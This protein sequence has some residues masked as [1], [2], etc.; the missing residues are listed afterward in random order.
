[1]PGFLIAFE[2]MDQSGKATQARQ[3][4]AR[5]EAAG[6]QVESLSFP[7]YKTSIGMEIGHALQG[8]RNY[9]PDTM[10]LL[11]MANRYEFRPRIEEWLAEGRFVICDRYTASSVAYGESQ[12]LDPSWVDSVQTGLPRAA[13]T[14]LLD[15]AAEH[16]ARRKEHDRDKYE[17][18]L[19][20]L[21][22]VR[23]SYLR[24]ARQHGWVVLDATRPVG[25]VAADVAREVI[26]RLALP[27]T[28]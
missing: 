6:Y 18:D 22:R 2:G 17:R 4:H 12:G 27:S 19:A 10:Q 20:M 26:S 9:G 25:E 24:Q 14:L 8:E 21:G 23:E 16:A 28:H 11:Y 15:L 13:V 5:L 1:M 7:D 3:L